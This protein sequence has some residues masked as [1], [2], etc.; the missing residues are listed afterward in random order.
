M[1]MMLMYEDGK[2]V[3]AVA[4]AQSDW[5]MRVVIRGDEDATELRLI[6]D[7][8]LSDEG[9]AVDIESI[10]IAGAT[11]GTPCWRAA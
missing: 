11:P 4:L 8:W 7:Q 6:K 9:D 10:L 3:E 5:R 1:R 2:R